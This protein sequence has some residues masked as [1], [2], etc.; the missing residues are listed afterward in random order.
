MG[1]SQNVTASSINATALSRSN[2]YSE[3]FIYYRHVQTPERLGLIPAFFFL[4]FSPLKR[5]K[6]DI[7]VEANKS[8]DNQTYY[9]FYGILKRTKH[10]VLGVTSKGQ[11]EAQD[12]NPLYLK[13][14]TF[15]W[16]K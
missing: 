11:D 14:K 1:M 10:R 15:D 16:I 3:N 7:T 13:K 9:C 12:V 8:Q 5:K 4:F 2:A 6:V